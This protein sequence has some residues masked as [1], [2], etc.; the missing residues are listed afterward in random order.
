MELVENLKLPI[1]NVL[2]LEFLAVLLISDSVRI[3]L[4]WKQIGPDISEELRDFEPQR[5]DLLIIIV[6]RLTLTGLK[7]Q[8][9]HA[10]V[11]EHVPDIT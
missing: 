6:L 8:I 9:A 5:S 10:L 7:L 1:F 11:F 4:D 2:F 3:F